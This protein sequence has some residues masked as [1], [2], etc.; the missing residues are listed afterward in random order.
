MCRVQ[1]LVKRLCLAGRC[2]QYYSPPCSDGPL[3]PGHR[4]SPSPSPSPLRLELTSRI[5]R[6]P[7]PQTREPGRRRQKRPVVSRL[8][9]ERAGAA[10]R[11]F[12]P[13]DCLLR[14]P[15]SPPYVNAARRMAGWYWY[16]IPFVLVALA[17]LTRLAASLANTNTNTGLSTSTTSTYEH[18]HGGRVPGRQ[19]GTVPKAGGVGWWRG[20]HSC[21]GRGQ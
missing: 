18:E 8:E 7:G 15:T 5:N 20:R 10:C 2:W 1:N 19:S 17:R 11:R 12:W 3:L 4:R 21:Q 6:R 16:S 13:C 9:P 14:L